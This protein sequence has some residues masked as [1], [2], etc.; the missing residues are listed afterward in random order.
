MQRHKQPQYQQL[1][2][3]EFNLIESRQEKLNLLWDEAQFI[4]ERI[5]NKRFVIKLYAFR[6]FNLELTYDIKHNEICDCIAITDDTLADDWLKDIDLRE[7]FDRM[8]HDGKRL[9]DEK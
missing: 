7:Y 3:A 5:D 4:T 9:E 8:E 2:P 6:D 1:T